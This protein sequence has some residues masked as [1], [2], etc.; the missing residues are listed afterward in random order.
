MSK[1]RRRRRVDRDGS[2]R[3]ELCGGTFPASAVDV[4]HRQPLALGGEDT[5]S[6]V[7]ALCRECH[8]GK[9]EREFT[10]G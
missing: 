6:N 9:T 3:C 5:D 4:D 7:Q 10:D 1:E 8:R 2:A